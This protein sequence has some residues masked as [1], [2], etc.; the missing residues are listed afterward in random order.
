MPR[1]F[2]HLRHALSAPIAPLPAT[3]VGGC[4]GQNPY[5]EGV[6]G[7]EAAAGGGGEAAVAVQLA[8]AVMRK[9]DLIRS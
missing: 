8:A 7:H 4:V 6:E 3:R 1:P 5:R 2:K 9:A